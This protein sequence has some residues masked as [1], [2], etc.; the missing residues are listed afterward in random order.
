MWERGRERGIMSKKR[1]EK[2][3]RTRESKWKE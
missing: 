2:G 1:I 3:I